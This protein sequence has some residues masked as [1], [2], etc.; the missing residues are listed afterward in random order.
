MNSL[1]EN[2]IGVVLVVIGLSA[3]VGSAFL[4]D[5]SLK[6]AGFGVLS[7]GLLAIKAPGVKDHKEA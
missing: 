1:V 4:K 2:I 7:A 6:D 3:M 5:S